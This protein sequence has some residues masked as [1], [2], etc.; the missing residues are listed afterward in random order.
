MAPCC[1]V[2]MRGDLRVKLGIAPNMLQD[3]AAAC[4]CPA[5]AMCQLHMESRRAG[6]D[7]GLTMCSPGTQIAPGQTKMG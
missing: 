6:V 3:V 5:C 1:L 4:C 7:P 2:S